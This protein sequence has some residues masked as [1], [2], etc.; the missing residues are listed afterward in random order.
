[1]LEENL[2]LQKREEP[3]LDFFPLI[4]TKCHSNKLILVYFS[5]ILSVDFDDK[6]VIVVG[7]ELFE[8]IDKT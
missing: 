3:Y 4:K 7:D 2:Y 6:R 1:M 8:S 5:H